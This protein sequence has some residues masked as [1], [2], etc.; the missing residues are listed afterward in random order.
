MSEN[1]TLRRT[2]FWAGV[3]LVCILGMVAIALGG[4]LVGLAVHV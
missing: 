2:A 1:N 4:L 3:V